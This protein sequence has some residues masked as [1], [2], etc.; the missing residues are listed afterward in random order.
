MVELEVM[1]TGTVIVVVV[2]FGVIVG[3][4]ETTVV[5]GIIVAVLF[6]HVV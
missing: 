3:Y 6:R 2:V 1:V 4:V 5:G